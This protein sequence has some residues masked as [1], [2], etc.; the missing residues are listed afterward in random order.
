MFPVEVVSFKKITIFTIYIYIII[1]EPLGIGGLRQNP[2]T[3]KISTP[4][5]GLHVEFVGQCDETGHE[6]LVGQHLQLVTYRTGKHCI[7]TCQAGATVVRPIPA[8][9]QNL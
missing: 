7:C 4:Q 9:C 6:E 2:A 8:C 1:F 3:A 5:L